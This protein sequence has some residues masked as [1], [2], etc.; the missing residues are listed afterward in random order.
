MNSRQDYRLIFAWKLPL[1]I[2]RLR[3][4]IRES[5]STYLAVRLGERS[6]TRIENAQPRKEF[7]AM[8]QIKWYGPTVLL[9]ITILLLLVAGPPMARKLAYAYDDAKIIQIRENLKSSPSLAELSD[10]FKQVARVVE[11]SVVSITVYS[12]RQAAAGN[13]NNLTPE[14]EEELRRYFFGPEGRKAPPEKVPAPRENFE[15]YDVPQPTGNGSGWV[16]ND[17]GLIITNNHVV[18]GADR[19]VVRFYDGSER[20]ATVVGTDA[21]TDVAVIKVEGEKLHAATRAPEPVDQGEIVFAFG[22]PFRF[23]FSMSQGI[24]S[25]KGRQLGILRG[26][27][28][29]ENFIQTDAAIN[30]GNSGGPLTN[31]YGEVVGMNTAIASRTGAYNGLGF[32]IPIKM[33]SNVA[34]QLIADGK[35][36]RGY[37]GV[38]I[39][40]L[41]PQLARSFGYDGRGVLVENPID[42][43]PGAKAGMQRGDII[44][45]VDGSSV[46][47]AD[48]LRNYVASLKPSTKVNVELHRLEK[49]TDL[50]GKLVTLELIIGEQPD[51]ASAL[52]PTPDQGKGADEASK[53][54]GRLGVDVDSNTEAIAKQLGT[55][56]VPGAIVKTV[57][58]GS[59]AEAAGLA[60]RQVITDVMGKAV[61][62]SKSLL[63]ELSK[64]DLSKGVRISV[65]DGDTPRFIFL[66]MSKH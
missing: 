49:P 23:D 10:S 51:S 12:K 28:G 6:L 29:Y 32:A 18:D 5:T 58:P 54:L 35:V 45:K 25:A 14:M 47:T 60:T 22:S 46:N 64:H 36:S 33:V 42:G 24:V 44:T 48:D 37:L 4:S 56:F 38:F 55:K 30:P 63:E 2:S 62:D 52:R 43:S 39:R 41:T 13:S 50:K 27:Q 65:M 16:Y 7:S 53:L 17:Q 19:V 57:R 31:I 3:L 8:K 34:D 66:E 61:T 11:K 9:L 20:D 15:E 21:K 59:A 1:D 26:N 40:D